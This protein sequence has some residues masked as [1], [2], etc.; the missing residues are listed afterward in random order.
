MMA[1]MPLTPRTAEVE[2]FRA[3]I[4]QV[5]PRLTKLAPGKPIIVAEFGCDFA[6]QGGG[7]GSAPDAL[8]DLF[9]RRWPAIIGFCW[10]NESW[11]NDDVVAHNSD[12]IILHDPALT[13]VFRT[14][15]E[16]EGDRIR[17]RRSFSANVRRMRFC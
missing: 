5:Y 7:S 2:T 3:E 15:L 8:H 12:M 17:R 4:D 1:L 11:E 14:E 6:S 9:D 10:W 16:K 13:S